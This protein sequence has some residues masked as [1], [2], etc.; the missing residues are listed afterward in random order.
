LR[1]VRSAQ[2]VEDAEVL[3]NLLLSAEE[4]A[5]IL[6]VEGDEAGIGADIRR[7]REPVVGVEPRTIEGLQKFPPRPVVAVP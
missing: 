4:Y 6:L 3:G 2:R 5:G 7:D 1:S